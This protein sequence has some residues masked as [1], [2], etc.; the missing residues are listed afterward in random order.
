MISRHLKIVRRVGFCLLIA[1]GALFAWALY[2]Y[3]TLP[4]YLRLA[5][6][7][8]F[9]L[10]VPLFNANDYF[11]GWASLTPR[12]KGGAIGWLFVPFFTVAA[13][14]WWYINF[15]TAKA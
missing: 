4:N 13:T 9:A 8:P 1:G 10:G 5:P 14:L 3:E 12:Q 2:R 7:V 6:F 15:P 11:G